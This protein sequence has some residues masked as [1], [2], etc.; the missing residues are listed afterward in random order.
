MYHYEAPL[1]EYRATLTLVWHSQH[2]IGSRPLTLYKCA[3]LGSHR[4]H[5]DCSLCVTRPKRLVGTCDK[6]LE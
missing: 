6:T 2:E 5:Q 3:V 4:R 1:A